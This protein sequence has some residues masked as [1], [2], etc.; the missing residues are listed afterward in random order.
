MGLNIYLVYAFL[1]GITFRFYASFLFLF[2]SVIG[3]MWISVMCLGVFQTLLMI[4]L[5]MINLYKSATIKDFADKLEEAHQEEEQQFLLKKKIRTGNR[6]ALYYWVNFFIQTISYLSLGRLF[7]TDFY[8]TP[9]DPNMLYSFVQYPSYPI[10]DVIFKLP[11]VGFNST[12][13]F[14]W[15]P[16]LISWAI[17]IGTQALVFVLRSLYKKFKAQSRSAI[18]KNAILQKIVA[19]FT[20]STVILCFLAWLLL[21][22]FPLDW[23]LM[24][25]FWR[26]Y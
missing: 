21:R 19:Y 26:Y 17:I 3:R 16:V 18:S 13:D 7:L 20:G 14:G 25:F 23:Q 2:Y 12:R 11:Y 1:T 22:H 6:T 24:I 8:R 5:R 10:Q 9:L 15:K 4:P